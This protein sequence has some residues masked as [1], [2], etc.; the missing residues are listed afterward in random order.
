MRLK[1]RVTQNCKR[2]PGVALSGHFCD[3]ERCLFASSLW[4]CG[5]HGQ[6]AACYCYCVLC[7]RS[8]AVWCCS[9]PPPVLSVTVPLHLCRSRAGLSELKPSNDSARAS[10]AGITPCPHPALTHRTSQ[11]ALPVSGE[12]GR[13]RQ[14]PRPRV[15]IGEQCAVCLVLC[16]PLSWFAWLLQNQKEG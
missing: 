3:R 5:R 1:Q 15:T 8:L 14:F 9:L 2:A 13:R 12:R 7:W 16:C 10:R 4:V 11:T 6:P